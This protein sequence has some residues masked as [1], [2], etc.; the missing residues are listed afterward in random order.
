MLRFAFFVLFVFF[1]YES[2]AQHADEAPIKTDSFVFEVDGN[3][4]VGLLDSPSTQEPVSTIIIVHG[5]G[6]TNVVEKNWFYELRSTFG[7][8]GINTLVWDKPG[9][10]ESE[11]E[12]D[13]DQPVQSSAEEVVAAVKAL[14]ERQIKGTEKI[15]LWGISRAGWIAPLAMQ[16]DPSIAFWISVSGTDDKEN[17]RYLL[18]SN[19]LIEGRTVEE[20]EVLVSEWQGRFNAAWKGG[21]YEEYLAASTHIADDEFMHFMGWGGTASEQEFLAYQALFTS[22]ELVVDET[23]E[24]LI[25]VPQ[26][27]QLLASIDRPVLALFGEKDTNVDWRKTAALYRDT[28]GRN[29][30]ASLEIRTFPDGD[31]TLRQTKTGGIRELLEQQSRPPYVEGYYESMLSWL[32]THQFGEGTF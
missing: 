8:I 7:K 29:P 4:L 19:F 11:G 1:A 23:E 30:N 32:N 15:G 12:F 9:C 28:I 16:A 3:K 22:G 17:A 20:T 6:A 18:E 21:T 2:S 27:K 13:I 10:G 31:H 26:F 14:K 25:Y 24:L 5:Y